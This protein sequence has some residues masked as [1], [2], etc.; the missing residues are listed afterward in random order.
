MTLLEN[1]SRIVDFAYQVF[2]QFPLGALTVPRAR[3]LLQDKMN[4]THT[5]EELKP[6][7]DRLYELCTSDESVSAVLARDPTVTPDEA[8]KRLYGKLEGKRAAKKLLDGVT[9]GSSDEEVLAQTA[10]CGKW[11]PT[12]PSELFLRVSHWRHS[13]ARTT[14]DLESY[15]TMLSAA[16]T[17]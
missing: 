14:A 2:F 4:V 6:I 5:H 1:L 15:T 13:R 12:Q 3:A 7:S 10:R 11:G 8:W 16:W 9:H 17:K